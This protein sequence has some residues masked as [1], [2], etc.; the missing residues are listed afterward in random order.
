[1]PSQI[2]AGRLRRTMGRE[3]WQAP[4]PFGG[5]GW[6]M[7][8]KDFTGSVIV[9]VARWEDGNEW[10]HASLAFSEEMPT[11]DD[12]VLLRAAVWGDDGWAFQVFAPPSDHI[13]IHPYALHLWG[14]LDG[15]RSHPD[16][17]RMG[18]I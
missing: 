15:V 7:T 14:R 1:M 9:S 13:S 2:P 8:R 16:F 18:T 6:K 3:K 10:V 17:G 11:Y 5:D 4:L 12:L